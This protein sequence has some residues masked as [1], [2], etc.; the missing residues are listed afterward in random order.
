M[1]YRGVCVEFRNHK[2]WRSEDDEFIT[3]T[4]FYREETES[5]FQKHAVK[6]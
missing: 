4:I 3:G 5:N 2:P 1:I 6:G